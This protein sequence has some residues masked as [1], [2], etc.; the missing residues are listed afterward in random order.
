VSKK[1]LIPCAKKYGLESGFSIPHPH[2]L[3]RQNLD[4]EVVVRLYRNGQAIQS[5]QIV[6]KGTESFIQIFESELGFVTSDSDLITVEYSDLKSAGLRF[7]NEI[8]GQIILRSAKNGSYI[9]ILTGMVPDRPP[10]YRF[11]PIIHMGHYLINEN[12]TTAM[13]LTNFKGSSANI[14]VSEKNNV[15]FDL[16]SKNGNLIGTVNRNVPLNS[17]FIYAIEQLAQDSKVEKS[18]IACVVARGGN[19]QFAIF[20]IIVSDSGAFGFEHSLAPF[21]YTEAVLN[22]K[23]RTKFLQKAFADL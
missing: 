14:D 9:S 19:S 21:Y 6:I 8:E 12:A 3:Q 17:T 23:T 20:T 22:P 13:I 16:Y 1:L 5:K 11:S 2:M 10:G 4:C 18:Q 7:A 15:R